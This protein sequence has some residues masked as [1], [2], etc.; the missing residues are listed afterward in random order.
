MQKTAC[1]AGTADQREGERVME[2][3]Y[4]KCAG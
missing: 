1:D 4:I 3:Q 2:N